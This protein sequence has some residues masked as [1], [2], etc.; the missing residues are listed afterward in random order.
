[1]AFAE[2]G[3]EIFVEE[4]VADF[5]LRPQRSGEAAGED[6]FGVEPV[7][8]A[9]EL[10][11]GVAAAH[12]GDEDFA[13]AFDA[14]MRREERRLLP[15]READQK[16]DGF[17]FANSAHL[18]PDNRSFQIWKSDTVAFTSRKQYSAI[19]RNFFSASNVP[20]SMPVTPW[21]FGD[22][23]PKALQ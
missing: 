16:G 1:Q 2:T 3:V 9:G 15:Y 17:R 22:S 14:R 5:Q 21:L 4:D 13:T 6:A 23:M 11:A 19:S 10:G 18:T 12:A 7:E 8:R 20:T